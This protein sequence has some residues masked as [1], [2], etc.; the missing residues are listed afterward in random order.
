[1]KTVIIHPWLKTGRES[2]PESELGEAVGLAEAINLEVVESRLVPLREVRPGSFIGKGKTQELSELV[3]E[4]EAGLVFMN[5]KLSPVQQRNLEKAWESKV[6]DRTGL[7]LEIFG[8]R[9]RTS[10]GQLQVEL[11]ALEYQK[12]RLVRSWT[13]LER[14]K[15]GFGFMG[16]PG[17]TQIELDRRMLSERIVKIKKE[18]ASVVRT[19]ELHRKTRRQVPYPV[20]ALVGYTNAGK[21]TLFNR[22]TGAGVVAED[23]LFA[24]L[25]P[26]MRLITLPSGRK[27]IL[28]DTVG[29]IS[30]LPTELVAAFRATLEEVLEADILVHVRDVSHPETL[31]QKANVEEV[32]KKLGA[33]AK[34]TLEALNKTDLLPEKPQ[35]SEGK[36]AIS[37]LTGEGC[38]KLVER[39]DEFSGKADNAVE[40]RLPASDGALIAWVYEHGEV[41]AREVEGEEIRLSAVLSP[42]NAERIK[43]MMSER[44]V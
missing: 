40:V 15:G 13:H 4:K 42:K 12:S 11:A 3:K 31:R 22:L 24:T 17:E 37:A 26:T 28:S 41:R 8:E 23:K 30:N 7:I 36:I 32:L 20:A 1:M 29:F 39:L 38:A 5:A 18:L 35:E 16:G 33:G 6:I 19:R 10:E 21:S 27:M 44:R 43:K 25:D 2:N 9:A 14:Q 34:E